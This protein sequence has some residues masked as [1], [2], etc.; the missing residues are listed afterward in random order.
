MRN[1]FWRVLGLWAMISVIALGAAVVLRAWPPAADAKLGYE[2]AK[3]VAQL[4]LIVVAGGLIVKEYEQARARRSAVHEFRRQVLRSII[5][6]YSEV[7]KIRRV[8]RAR[9][10]RAAGEEGGA[11][12]ES[13][14]A[15]AYDA[16]M[17]RLNEIQI[18]LEVLVRELKVFRET[19][20]APGELTRQLVAMERYLS[21]LTDEWE[22]SRPDF[23]DRPG[24]P[25][26]Q[27]PR[28]EAFLARRPA[29]DFKAA[30]TRPFT[31]AL[32]LIQAE[33]LKVG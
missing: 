12:V 28:L 5:G 4:T 13:I 25:V 29:G 1:P 10:I 8:L 16:H 6:A 18:E 7:K 23:G 21:A 20:D 14:P 24:S 2:I 31:A 19:F 27:L 15:A 22:V 3:F 17:E 9:C 32:D 30:Y 33:R 11:A 26:G